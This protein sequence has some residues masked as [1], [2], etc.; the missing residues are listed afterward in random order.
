MPFIVTMMWTET[1]N[2]VSDSYFCPSDRNG[3][4][5]K[6]NH[7]IIYPNL[8]S[9]IR[10]V[11]HSKSLPKSI[12]IPSLEIDNPQLSSSYQYVHEDNDSEFEEFI[13]KPHLKT[14]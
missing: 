14:Q 1:R 9:F 3:I 8:P 6:K 12:T 4:N 2:H 10:P 7:K 11:F 13:S 5:Y